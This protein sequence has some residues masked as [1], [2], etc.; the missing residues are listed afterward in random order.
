M[1]IDRD[2]QKTGV[3][4]AFRIQGEHWQALLSG[5]KDPR[6]LLSVEGYVAAAELALG[7]TGHILWKVAARF[8]FLLLVALGV[9]AAAAYLSITYGAGTAKVWTFAVSVITGLGLTG[10][11]LEVAAKR[12][13]VS[14]GTSLFSAS[15]EEV[16]SAEILW[17]PH[18]KR[19]WLKDR[20]LRRKGIVI[21]SLDDSKKQSVTE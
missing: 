6:S 10:K 8:S 21:R 19:S 4:R 3:K 12:L 9:T 7:R 14:A 17:L 13:A 15:E 16:I 11:G 20:K 1:A 5:D 2:E 18:F